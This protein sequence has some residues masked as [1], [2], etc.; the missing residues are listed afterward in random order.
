MKN[1]TVLLIEPSV[2]ETGLLTAALQRLELKVLPLHD[3]EAALALLATPQPVHLVLANWIQPGSSGLEM[4][5]AVRRVARVQVPVVLY[6]RSVDEDAEKASVLHG[7]AALLRSP[8]SHSDLYQHLHPVLR[9]R[10]PW[11]FPEKSV[12]GDLEL[13]RERHTVER[14]GKRVHLTPSEFRILE[15]LTR[16]RGEVLS[17]EA[18]YAAFARTDI[19]NI[20]A[21]DVHIQRLKAAL[22]VG[23]SA[24]PIRAVRGKGY[25]ID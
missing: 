2:A 1:L 7:V 16:R 25:M 19:G 17:R 15:T 6:A 4:A 10:H 11:A 5:G 12:V 18:L 9:D 21:V 13:D 3:G 14:R 24:P 23:G 8:I 22:T 20:R